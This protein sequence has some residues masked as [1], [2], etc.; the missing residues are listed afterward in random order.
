[1]VTKGYAAPEVEQTY[2]RARDLVRKI[3]DVPQKFP[4]LFG[5]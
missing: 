5:L 2:L 1:M 4:V 3:G